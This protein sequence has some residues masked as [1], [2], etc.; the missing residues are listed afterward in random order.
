MQYKFIRSPSMIRVLPLIG[1]ALGSCHSHSEDYFDLELDQLINVPVEVA[2]LFEESALDVASSTAVITKNNI[3]DHGYLTLGQSL[4]SVPSVFTTTTWGGSEAISIRGYSTELSVRGT[5]YYLD[6]IPLGTYVYASTSY[7]LPRAPLGLMNSVE[8]IRGPGS[9]LYGTDAFHGVVRFNLNED[10]VNKSHAFAQLGNRDLKDIQ[11]TNSHYI[12]DWQFHSGLQYTEDGDHDLIFYYDDPFTGD[13]ESGRRDHA[14]DN[15]GLFIKASNGQITGPT[16]KLSLSLFHNTFHSSEFQGVGSQ[17]FK[18]YLSAFDLE[19]A[20]LT[21]QGD[22]SGSDSHLSVF[23]MSH[24]VLLSNQLQLKNTAYHWT[25]QQEWVFDNRNYPSEMTTLSGTTLPCI[26]QEG[27]PGITELYCSHI[28]YQGADESRSGYSVQLKNPAQ[29]SQWVLGAGIDAIKVDDSTFKRINTNGETIQ[30]IENAY[31]NKER[32]IT[33][34][35]AQGKSSF[36]DESILMTYGVRWD[37]YSDVSD[38]ASPRL[39]VI[40]KLSSN[41]TQK[42][43]YGH[44]YRAPTAIEQ[45]GSGPVLGGENLKAETIDTTE[46]VLVYH[47]EQLQIEGVVFYSDWQ[48]AIALVRTGS[49]TEQ[50]YRNIDRNYSRGLELS[51]KWKANSHLLIHGS[52]SYVDSENSTEDITYDA[53]PDWLTQLHIEYSIPSSRF[54]VGL[55]HRAMLDYELSDDS[56]LSADNDTENYHRTDLYSHWNLSHDLKIGMNIQNIFDK[57]N[58]LPSYYESQ[59]GLPDYGL[60]GKVTLDYQF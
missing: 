31:Q 21:Q 37:N 28:L 3:R 42:L 56:A 39:G 9:T 25:A 14:F 6:D 45:F 58:A 11:L 30:T 40:H 55:G 7:I 29:T 41:W 32:V 19:N 60:L 23:G 13:Q 26:P 47:D 18:A 35:M 12:S 49:G 57:D 17:F 16:G 48:D 24:E 34:I 54:S 5:A 20:N 38:H 8:M 27:Q 36:S 52:M 4:E 1:L 50:I 59:G 43:L 22:I 44:A 33:H 46:Y 2:S 10:N 53:F 15:L 51:G